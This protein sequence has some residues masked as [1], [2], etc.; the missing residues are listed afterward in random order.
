MK[1]AV[2]V[3]VVFIIALIIDILLSVALP[4][5]VIKWIAE[6][7]G[8]ENSFWFFFLIVLVI[9]FFIAIVQK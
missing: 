5:L 7:A 9:R 3:I 8:Y 1:E 2:G 6:M 4:A